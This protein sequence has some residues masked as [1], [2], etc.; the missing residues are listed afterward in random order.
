MQSF[1]IRFSGGGGVV[2]EIF[3]ELVYRIRFSGGGGGGGSD[4]NIF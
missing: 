4:R 2:T 1:T 3:R